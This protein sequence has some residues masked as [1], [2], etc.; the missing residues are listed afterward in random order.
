VSQEQFFNFNKSNERG[1][2][3]TSVV[4]HESRSFSMEKISDF[5]F[6]SPSMISYVL[7]ISVNRSEHIFGF[8][9]V[10]LGLSHLHGSNPHFFLV[11]LRLPADL[12]T[13]SCF[14][15]SAIFLVSLRQVAV[16][17]LQFNTGTIFLLASGPLGP[18]QLRKQA[19]FSLTAHEFPLESS[20]RR[21]LRS[22]WPGSASMPGSI[23]F[24]GRLG[25]SLPP[26][27]LSPA[28]GLLLV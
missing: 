16:S 21:L 11:F 22:A 27:N 14:L 5:G 19:R 23:F 9:F 15:V 28:P 4:V 3:V 18:I 12:C 1:R 10:S 26:L 7:A 8:L 6:W 24:A 25:F 17:T 13:V 20:P 2:A